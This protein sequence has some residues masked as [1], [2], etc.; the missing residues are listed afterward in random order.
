MENSPTLRELHWNSLELFKKIQKHCWL[1]TKTHWSPTRDILPPAP[2]IHYDKEGIYLYAMVPWYGR[3]NKEERS[4]VIMIPWMHAIPMGGIPGIATTT[5]AAEAA[6][7][8]KTLVG[9]HRSKSCCG[10]QQSAKK[11]GGAFLKG[12][13]DSPHAQRLRRH[14]THQPVTDI[15]GHITRRRTVHHCSFSVHFGCI[16]AYGKT[17]HRWCLTTCHALNNYKKIF[18]SIST[19]LRILRSIQ[20]SS[21]C[22]P[23]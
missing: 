17:G 6:G 7:T 9:G 21:F 10:N 18:S 23:Y 11:L 13:H 4:P 19:S 2:N 14:D 3:T 5:I 16:Y 22:P 8:P 20:K 1:T 15:W 12:D